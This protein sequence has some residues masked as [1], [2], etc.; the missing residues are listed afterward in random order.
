MKNHDQYL[1]RKDRESHTRDVIVQGITVRLIFAAEQNR[2]VPAIVRNLL[3]GSYL[4]RQ[5][6]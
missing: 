3:K 6:V 2:E 5:G 4:Q 1:N